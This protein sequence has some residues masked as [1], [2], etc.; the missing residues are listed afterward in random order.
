MAVS[1]FHPAE[2]VKEAYSAGIRLFGESRVQEALSKFDDALKAGLPGAALHMIGN[3]QSNKINKALESFD[4]IQSIGS[5]ELLEAVAVRVLKTGREIP[6][7]LEL[8]TGEA[9]KAGF[10]DVEALLRAVEEEFER[11]QRGFYREEGGGRVRLAGLMTM[12]PYTDSEPELRR[13]FRILAAC[14]EKVRKGFGLDRFDE[15]SMGMSGD[16]EIAI[17]E[18]STLV[19]VGTALFGERH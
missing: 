8:H 10:P 12:A 11:E 7:L 18:G 3:L 19:R 1:K 4:C 13:S 14:A 5:R 9:S 17:E 15:L 2:A 6:L 16:F